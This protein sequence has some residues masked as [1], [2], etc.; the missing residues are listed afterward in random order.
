MCTGS[1]PLSYTARLWV[2]LLATGLLAGCARSDLEGGATVNVAVGDLHVA[3]PIVSWKAIQNRNVV[4][5]GLDYSCGAAALA[6]LMQ[7]YFGSQVTENE[8]LAD[9]LNHLTPVQVEKVRLEGFSMLDLKNA[10]ERHGYQ[11]EGVRID[12]NDLPLLQGPVLVYLELTNSRHFAILRGVREDRVYLADPSRGNLRLRIDRFADEWPSGIALV[13]EKPGFG[14]PANTALAI[15]RNQ[16][17]RTELTT[18][19]EGL[20]AIDALSQ[21][22]RIG[23]R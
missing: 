22:P 3:K 1:K 10:A 21:P 6:T 23:L 2:L 5:Q 17:F 9:M 12:L 15:D 18:A 16:P 8:L 7:Y 4:M 11:A 20:Y 14:T 19:R 13:L